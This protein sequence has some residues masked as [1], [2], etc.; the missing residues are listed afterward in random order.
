[1]TRDWAFCRF[2][3]KELGVTAIPPSAFY[4]GKEKELASNLARFAFCKEDKSLYEAGERLMGL[5]R[6][7]KQ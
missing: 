6:F 1:M 2:L 7:E 3:T 5:R 4:E